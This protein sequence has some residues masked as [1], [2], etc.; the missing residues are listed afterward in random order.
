MLFLVL[1]QI[2]DQ[3]KRTAIKDLI[4]YGLAMKLPPKDSW[5]KGLA[6]N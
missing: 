1:D 6:A 4:G 5:V 3:A 2:L